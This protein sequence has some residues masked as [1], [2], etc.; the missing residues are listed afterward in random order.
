MQKLTEETNFY[1]ELYYQNILEIIFNTGAFLI[2]SIRSS[3]M[4]LITG[5]ELVMGIKMFQIFTVIVMPYK[6]YLPAASP[7][8]LRSYFS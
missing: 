2:N 1:V 6:K 5:F 4:R 7:T 8:L 3:K